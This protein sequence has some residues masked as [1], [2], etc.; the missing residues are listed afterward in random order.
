MCLNMYEKVIHVECDVQKYLGKKFTSID[1]SLKPFVIK[2]PRYIVNLEEWDPMIFRK[3]KRIGRLWFNL[4]LVFLKNIWRRG[5]SWWH[6][7]RKWIS[8]STALQLTQSLSAA[9]IPLYR[10]SS[11]RSLWLLILNLVKWTLSITD[12][13]IVR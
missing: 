5:S 3:F 10:P 13:P 7:K 12:K 11:I 6:P 4:I 9:G 1:L 8:S 2:R